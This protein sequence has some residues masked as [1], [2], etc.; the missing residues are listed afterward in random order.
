MQQK[1][2]KKLS[3][4]L[5]FK[6]YRKFQITSIITCLE[7]YKNIKTMHCSETGI[8]LIYMDF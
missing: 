2:V 8:N 7:M 3:L 1:I 4:L 5:E 6:A